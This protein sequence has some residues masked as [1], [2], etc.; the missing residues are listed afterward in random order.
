MIVRRRRRAPQFRFASG[1]ASI[2]IDGYNFSMSDTPRQYK[3]LGPDPYSSYKQWRVKG[4]R[5]SARTL[6]SA[7]LGEDAM[8][9]E[10]VAADYDLPLEAVLEAIDYC[11][12]DPPE[13]KEDLAA[14]ERLAKATGMDD[15]ANRGKQPKHLTIQERKR[16]G[17]L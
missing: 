2:S 3:Y 4:R 6:Y 7:T 10:Q 11:K 13:I 16:L 5:I 9:P 17:L 14:D 8:T 12:S 15:P 1:L